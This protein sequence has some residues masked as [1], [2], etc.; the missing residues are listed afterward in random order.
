MKHFY[1]K[2]T[3]ITVIVIALFTVCF[4]LTHDKSDNMANGASAY[5]LSSWLAKHNISIDK[6]M[7]DISSHEVVSAKFKNSLENHEAAANKI[8]GADV[9]DK[10]ADTYKGERGTVTFSNDVFTLSPED[11]VFKTEASRADRYN[12]G[13]RAEEM[14]KEMGFDLD[15]SIIM[16]SDEDSC[17]TAKIMKTVNSLPVFNNCITITV[18][19]KSFVS[20]S[21]I[22]YVQDS[23]AYKKR[24]AKSAADAL[25][26]LL[27][28]VDGIGKVT[29]TSMTLGYKMEK[30][31]EGIYVIHP[32]WKFE[33]ANRDDIYIPA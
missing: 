11:G 32:F 5:N 3:A 33:L 14:A 12:I 23:G 24:R 8:L 22:W 9:S 16:T 27:K 7:I 30:D 19:N 6:D 20:A 28:E 18:E 26:G 13:K 10:G 21:G 15:G 29:V 2:I 25:A 1:I 4:R 17:Y 31:N